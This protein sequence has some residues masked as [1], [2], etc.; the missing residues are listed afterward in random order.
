MI[1]LASVDYRGQPGKFA[2]FWIDSAN[3]FA[4]NE[5]PLRVSPKLSSAAMVDWGG[6]HCEEVALTL[7]AQA[8]THNAGAI[9]NLISSKKAA[10][11][12]L[13]KMQQ[14]QR[15]VWRLSEAWR[16]GRPAAFFMDCSQPK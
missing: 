11:E 16:A 13:V 4:R 5:T 1:K 7:Q 2:K 9:V 6:L 3:N 10:A 15:F 14:K 8:H 12:S